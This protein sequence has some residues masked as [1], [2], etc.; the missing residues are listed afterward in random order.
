MSTGTP[1]FRAWLLDGKAG[2]AERIAS[3]EV[4]LESGLAGSFV[5]LQ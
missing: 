3:V 5:Q 4:S 2:R 1:K